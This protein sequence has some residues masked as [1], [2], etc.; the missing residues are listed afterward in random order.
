[1]NSGGLAASTLTRDARAVAHLLVWADRNRIDLDA[2]FLEGAFLSH[3]EVLSLARAAKQPLEIL[4]TKRVHDVVVTKPPY[5]VVSTEKLRA[6]PAPP[7]RAVCTALAG[8]RIWMAGQYLAWLA[9]AREPAN[10]GLQELLRRETEKA[11]MV[12]AIEAQVG[13]VPS[14]PTDP[15]EGLSPEQQIRLRDVIRP[16]STENPWLDQF[17]KVRNQAFIE[18]LLGGGPRSGEM[19]KQ[20]TEHVNMRRQELRIVRNPDDTDDPRFNE[21]NVKRGGRNV[22][23]SEPLSSYIIDYICDWRSQIPGSEK[24]PYL[25]LSR[26]GSPLSQESVQKM[27]RKLRDSISDL[28]ANLTAHLLRH[29][30]NDNFSL[31][32]DEKRV[33]ESKEIKTRS[34]LMGWKETSGTAARYTRRSTRKRAE[35]VS[36]KMQEDQAAQRKGHQQ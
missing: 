36:R 4:R 16:E 29:T 3:A 22:P 6:P 9:N 1:M 2:R 18:L 35:A 25:F 24:S 20:R 17:V 13:G 34:Y 23:I 14:L 31:A 30:W 5:Q 7:E 27:F 11:R 19:L 26:N 33:P 21:P 28:P 15:K 10:L 8:H 32:M 12:K